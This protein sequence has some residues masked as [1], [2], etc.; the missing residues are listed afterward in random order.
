MRTD[1]IPS[2]VELWIDNYKRKNLIGYQAEQWLASFPFEQVNV[3]V[4]HPSVIIE[5]FPEAIRPKVKL[6]NNVMRH[7]NA[8]GPMARSYNQ[9]YTHTFLSGKKYCICAHDGMQIIPGWAEL[10]IQSDYDLYFAPQGDQVH[11]ITLEGLKTFGWWD[12]RYAMNGNHELDYLSRALHKAGIKEEGRASLVDIHGWPNELPWVN[13][14][15]LYYNSV[16]LE[17]HWCRLPRHT[18]PPTG[19]KGELFQQKLDQ[20]HFKKWRGLEATALINVTE[21]PT[22]AEIDWYPWLDLAT[23]QVASCGVQ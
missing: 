3:I 4:N 15:H 20:W 1:F 8:I 9:A 5:D 12:E 11:L 13:G 16:G 6:W 19:E 23:L 18:V 2:N 22:E 10:I 21:G 14:N 7:P 17:R